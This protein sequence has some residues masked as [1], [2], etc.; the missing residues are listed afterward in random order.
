MWIISNKFIY[1]NNSNNCSFLESNTLL[2]SVTEFAAFKLCHL[3]RE[4]IL[5]I[6]LVLIH[7][8]DGKTVTGDRYDFNTSTNRV[9]CIL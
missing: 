8:P 4:V 9:E 3:R 1:Y 5:R 7:S 6:I 2:K